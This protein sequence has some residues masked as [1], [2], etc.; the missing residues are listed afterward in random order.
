[1][2]EKLL[3]VTRL[4]RALLVRFDES[5]ADADILAE[6]GTGGR[7]VSRT[8]LASATDPTRVAHLSQSHGGLQRA[9]S[10]V[11]VG[12]R[13][14]L[15]ARVVVEGDEGLYLYLDGTGSLAAV[16]AGMAEV[17]GAAARIC[18]LVIESVARR[19]LEAL[20]LDV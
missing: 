12:V 6:A 13:E 16:D 19:R 5:R 11:A 15:C 3:A 9:E 14:A 8:V 17:V 20:R 2:L 10:I 7:P 4:D 18:W 1:M